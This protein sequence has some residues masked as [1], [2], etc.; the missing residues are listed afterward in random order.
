MP[1]L[2]SIVQKLQ[3]GPVRF[4]PYVKDLGV[5]LRP[6]RFGI[7]GIAVVLVIWFDSYTG[8]GADVLIAYSHSALFGGKSWQFFLGLLVFSLVVWVAMYLAVLIRFKH[9]G[10]SEPAIMI[11]YRTQYP[12]PI[13]VPNNPGA[14]K[15]AKRR[16]KWIL[17]IRRIMPPAIGAAAP[18]VTAL[19]L[20]AAEGAQAISEYAIWLALGLCIFLFAFFG[21]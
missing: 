4:W 10:Q 6:V 9:D 14:R 19:G 11:R 2:W 17:S 20:L 21:R 3:I 5:A 1:R 12:A 15:E 18:L 8:Q 13:F 16:V 7:L